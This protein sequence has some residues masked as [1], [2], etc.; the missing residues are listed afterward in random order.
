MDRPMASCSLPPR[1]DA[2]AAAAL[3]NQLLA[4]RGSDL[5]VDASRVQQISGLGVQVLLSAQQTWR[6]D[7]ARFDLAQPSEPFL[8]TQR[9]LG[10]QF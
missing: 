5:T 3:R 8:T 9:H 1:V 2:A 10:V 4:A 6:T 7:G